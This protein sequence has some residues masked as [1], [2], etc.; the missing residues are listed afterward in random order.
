MAKTF[1]VTTPIFYVSAEPHIGSAY[2]TLFSDA[3]ARFYKLNGYD[4]KF[5][6][7]T[8]EHGQK[9][10]QYAIKDGKTP[11]A[12]VDNLSVRFRKILETLDFHPTQFEYINDNFIRTTS[13]Q[14]VK[15]VQEVWKRLVNN[16]WIYEGKY[17][18][19]YCVSDEAYYTE[20]DLIKQPDGTYKTQ[21]GAA[22]EW[23]E[24]A[25]Y[26]FR[27]SEFQE[28]LLK[29]YRKF[30]NLVRPI[31]KLTEVV[32]FVSG[33][34]VKDYEQGKPIEK[35]RLKDLSVSRNSF[36]WGVK[37]P[38][39][40]TGRELLDNGSWKDSIKDSERHVIYVWLD[41]L[42]NYLTALG[43]DTGEDYKTYWLNGE[44][45]Y[46]LIGKDILR[47]H[48]VYWPAM[49]L[50]YNY[51]REQFLKMQEPLDEFVKY[52]PS[53]IFAH[54]WLTND[55][56]KI[57]KSLGNGIYPSNEIEW[58]R[59]FGISMEVARDYFKYYMM[60]TVPFGNDGDYSR[61][62]LLER[63]NGDL[64]NKVGNLAKRTLDLIYK[65]FNKKIP[66]LEQF[67]AIST[68]TTDSL[69]EY[70]DNLD[71]VGYIDASLSL[72]EEAN[73]YLEQNEPWKLHR[74]GRVNE[75]A[76]VLYSSANTIRKIA[77][78][79]QPIVPYLARELLISLGCEGEMGMTALTTNLADNVINEPKILMPR[80]V[81]K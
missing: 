81:E 60:T 17:D 80:L 29:L 78:L 69:Q 64:V 8:D 34:G 38:C 51:P 57:S 1:Y 14:H 7:G 71:F 56:Q 3:M 15:F 48:A 33:L 13:P 2:P 54:G 4:V 49:L 19:W 41:A 10:Q 50:A 6:T 74:D 72:A 55:G 26:F 11:K 31:G 59:S 75:E 21:L 77:I 36:D 46:H 28:M 79:L 43:C 52:L 68:A 16:G 23:R 12:F 24:E 35:G 44:K 47:F 9:V 61:K 5:L 39:D 62:Q 27:L 73:K 67:D 76:K 45:K 65:N 22:V 20:S 70:I 40:D 58:L 66:R 53:T 25:S 32:A 63:V 30:P 18:G 42:F 37:I